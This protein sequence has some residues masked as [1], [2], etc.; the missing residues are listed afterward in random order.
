[1]GHRHRG[2]KTGIKGGAMTG[3]HHHRREKGQTGILKWGI[4]IA[5]E[6]MGKGLA[7]ARVEKGE[8][9]DE[10]DMRGTVSRPRRGVGY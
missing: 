6:E 8:K 4:S 3:R 7:K 10:K 1:M 5:G 9:S 2:V